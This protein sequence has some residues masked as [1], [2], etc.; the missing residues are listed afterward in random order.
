MARKS[1]FE[2]EKRIDVLDETRNLISFL[3]KKDTFS[4]NNHYNESFIS[5]VNY[6]FPSWSY[7]KS[8]LSCQQYFELYGIDVRRLTEESCLY[9]L[10]F[11]L[12]ICSWIPAQIEYQSSYSSFRD[13]NEQLISGIETSIN[14]I[15]EGV[16]YKAKKVKDK[17]LIYKR[18]AD[19]DSTI[20]LTSNS[21]LATLLLQ[22]LD[23][24]NQNSVV[25]KGSILASLNIWIEKNKEEYKKINNQLYKDVS[26]IINNIGSRHKENMDPPLTRKE[27]LH[28]M[29]NC[30][31]LMLY[32]IRSVELKSIQNELNEV[33]KPRIS[34]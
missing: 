20:S 9:L 8:A 28:W 30:F 25:E 2:L 4:W 19:V 34:S 1:I 27:K 24:R 29:D 17:V 22:Y 5:M 26:A 33:F 21:D 32:L 15:L 18:N 16:N 10:E 31:H 14:S 7:K 11:L 3:Y 13:R 6:Y 23:F 12:N